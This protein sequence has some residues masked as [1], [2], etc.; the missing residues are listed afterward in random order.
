LLHAAHK[1]H[2]RGDGHSAQPAEKQSYGFVTGK[3]RRWENWETSF[4]KMSIYY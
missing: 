3:L 4:Y 2:S 1:I